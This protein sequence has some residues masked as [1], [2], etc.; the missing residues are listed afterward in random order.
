M[1][2]NSNPILLTCVL[3][4]SICDMKCFL[5][6]NRAKSKNG[7]YQLRQKLDSIGLSLPPGRRKATELSLFTSLVEGTIYYGIP[8]WHHH[9]LFFITRR[10]GSLGIRF[11]QHLWQS[12]SSCWTVRDH[13]KTA[14][15]H[16]TSSRENQHGQR[17]K[18]SSKPCHSIDVVLLH[19][20]KS[21]TLCVATSW[22]YWQLAASIDCMFSWL[23]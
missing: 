2:I 7:G 9:Q 11:Q 8:C 16:T 21:L 3:P 5:S 17:S 10:S 6:C 15:R 23:T 22:W 13:R 14:C 4:F 18:V 1:F 19:A 12:F 20:M